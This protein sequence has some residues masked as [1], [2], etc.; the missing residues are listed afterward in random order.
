MTIQTKHYLDVSAAIEST[1]KAQ[2]IH[3]TT[4][5]ICKSCTKTLSIAEFI[6]RHC[7][8]CGRDVEVV[9]TKGRP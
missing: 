3:S 9:A 8:E 1:R 6:E 4:F 5:H 7:E 2:A